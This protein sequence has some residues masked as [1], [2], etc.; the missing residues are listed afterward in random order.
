MCRTIRY[1]RWLVVGAALVV[2]GTASWC[3]GAKPTGPRSWK[4]ADSG[5]A[6]PMALSRDGKTLVSTR[7]TIEGLLVEAWSTATGRRLWSQ[8]VPHAIVH[9]SASLAISPDQM[10]LAQT[11]YAHQSPPIVLR[12]MKRGTVVRGLQ[13]DGEQPSMQLG[14]QPG[15]RVTPLG[16]FTKPFFSPDGYL[17]AVINGFKPNELSLWDVMTGRHL[18]MITVGTHR[19][20]AVHFSP[21]SQWMAALARPAKIEVNEKVHEHGG[22]S[23]QTRITGTKGDYILYVWD[24]KTRRELAAIKL[25]HYGA[26]GSRDLP[27]FSPDGRFFAYK[28]VKK[29]PDDKRRYEISVCVRE[30][31][32]GD[33]KARLAMTVANTLRFSDDGKTVFGTNP[34]IG[35]HLVA[36]VGDVATGEVR[37]TI[38]EQPE[39]RSLIAT[40][41]SPYG[42]VL[43]VAGNHHVV[44]LRRTRTGEKIA[45]LQG[46][47]KGFVGYAINRPASG[48]ELLF[49]SDDGSRLVSVGMFGKSRRS[50]GVKNGSTKVTVWNVAEYTGATA[51]R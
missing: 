17:L 14:Q 39:E 5:L 11:L 38:R 23:L 16:D 7:H 33:E 15:R 8:Q 10:L 42:E 48:G 40:A 9:P 27:A 30:T 28:E 26:L 4:I 21:D 35:A 51:G 22:R 34:P 41:F 45:T 31:K 36:E 24:T 20:S 6:S 18:G 12:E 3:T 47:R 1:R 32:T 37:Q 2:L 49:F 29:L 13:A 44:E 19:L 50:R 25:S 43:A 46:P